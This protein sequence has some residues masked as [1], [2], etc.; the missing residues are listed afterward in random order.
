MM[1][2]GT[3]VGFC[4]GHI[5][6]DGDLAPLHERGTAPSFRPISFV[7]NGWMDQDV[8]GMQV[9]LSPSDIVLDGDAASL[10]KKGVQPLNFRPM[11]IVA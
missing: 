10:P 1:I 8:I 2:L 3:Q 4:P 9:G 11:F 7:P 6:L 5:V